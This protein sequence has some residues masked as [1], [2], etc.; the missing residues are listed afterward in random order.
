MNLVLFG[1]PGAGKGTQSALMIE[2]LK[3]HQISTG[4]LFRAAIKNGTPLGREAKSYIDAGGLVPDSITIGLVEEEL[5]KLSGQSFVLD[6][7]PRNVAQAEALEVLLKRLSL[8]LERIVFL[9]VPLQSLMGR[10]AGRRVCKA[11]G[12]VYNVESKPTKVEGVCDVCG[13]VVVQR[14]DDKED[15]VRARLEAYELSTRPLKEYYKVKGSYV[16]VDGTGTSEEVYG[17]MLK[18]LQVKR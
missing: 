6:G 3:V 9:E 11:C 8:T 1:P 17:R 13:G 7:F 15:V 4:D 10:L 18:A 16:E 14:P 2:R 12:A 5:G